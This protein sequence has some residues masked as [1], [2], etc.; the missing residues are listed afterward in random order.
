V[1]IRCKYNDSRQTIVL[2]PGS[3]AVARWVLDW[4]TL[5]RLT[6]MSG[7]NVARSL[8]L[9]ATSR[10]R[11]LLF[12]FPLRVDQRCFPAGNAKYAY[13]FQDSRHNGIGSVG[14]AGGAP[15]MNGTLKIFPQSGYVV[16]VLSNLDPP[17]AQS[18]AMFLDLRLGR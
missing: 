4:L 16:A 14:H 5:H 8:L 10:R 12:P 17:A 18:V 11:F 7:G 1:P 2:S 9:S 3:C 13:G 15:G 6:P